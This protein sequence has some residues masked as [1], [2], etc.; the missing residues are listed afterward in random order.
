MFF[1]VA[2][3]NWPSDRP[4][5]YRVL[6]FVVVESASPWALPLVSR[7]Q[8]AL[9]FELCVAK[10]AGVPHGNT[11]F[12]LERKPDHVP[13]CDTVERVAYAL[14][15]SPAFLAYGIE[16]DASQPTDGLRCEGVASRL[17]ETRTARGLTMR[18]L[19]RAAGLT[20]PP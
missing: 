4:T 14:G 7:E 8:E 2:V 11:V 15:L 12:Q 9:Q 16:A 5:C 3:T 20:I 13:R 10:A 18:A 6:W 19:A 1:T 17:R